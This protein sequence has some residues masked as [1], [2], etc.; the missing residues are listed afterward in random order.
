[1]DPARY[2]IVPIGI[3]R[4][5]RWRLRSDAISLLKQSAPR[6]QALGRG[7][8]PVS[9]PPYPHGRSLV[10]TSFSNDAYPVKASNG[11]GEL[12]PIDLIFP[13]LHGTFGEDGT[14]QGLLELAGIPYVGAGVLG[15]AIGMDKD[16][17]KRLLR[18]GGIPVVRYFS[19]TQA[20]AANDRARTRRLADD[21][22]YPM[23]VKPNALG[24]SIGVSRVGSPAALTGA[25]KE[26][27]QYD[28]KVLLEAGCE[29][30]E[31]ECAVLG[32][33]HPQASVVG[34]VMVHRRHR[35]YSYES[36]Y[37]DPRG[38]EIKI[39][40]SLA[41]SLSDH[42]REL[43]TA[44]FKVLGLRGMARV[45]FLARADLSEWFVNEV[46]TIPGFTAISM[47]PKLWEATD[48]PLPRLI[49]RLIELALEEHRQRARLKFTYQPQL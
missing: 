17:Q 11:D 20:E 42:I 29:G 22:G 12:P 8:T 23:F 46:N 41:L 4:D 31:F 9:L 34:E 39:P 27:F 36:K 15:S 37:V 19:L 10:A 48:L 6:L 45:D 5:G 24:S 40:A 26:A 1:M 32:N 43:S 38:A 44:A 49:D 7:G 18:E 30:R 47:F 2:E 35:F 33:D 25:L 14:I 16:I 3:T 13:M 28:R 21:L